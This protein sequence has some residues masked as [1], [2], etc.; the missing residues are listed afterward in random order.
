MTVYHPDRAEPM[1]FACQDGYDM[2]IGHLIDC[3]T[4]DRR[5][6]ATLE[7]A[8]AVTKT[9]EA[10]LRSIHAGTAMSVG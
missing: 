8:L 5:P 7:D 2:E 1:S 6:R 10:E 9:I 4:H 3:I